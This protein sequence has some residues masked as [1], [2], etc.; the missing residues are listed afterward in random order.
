MSVVMD[1]SPTDRDL[2]WTLS[3]QDV[4]A[5][6]ARR[7]VPDDHRGP[8]SSAESA[9]YADARRREGQLAREQGLGSPDT[10]FQSRVDARVRQRHDD[11][12]LSRSG[13]PRRPRAGSPAGSERSRGSRASARSRTSRGSRGSR[14]SHGDFG[15]GGGGPSRAASRGGSRRLDAGSPS[16]R[17][18]EPP[19]SGD[20]RRSGDREDDEPGCPLRGEA[21][22]LEKQA[23]LLDLERMRINGVVLSRGYDMSD[24]LEDMRFEIQKHEA[25]LDEK[26]MV[27]WMKS[28]LRL[29]LTG[30]ELG[31]QKFGPFLALDGWSVEIT[32]DMNK[33]DLPMSRLYRK[34]W[35]RSTMSP[36]MELAWVILGS[37]GMFHLRQKGGALLS[38]MNPGGPAAPAGAAYSGFASEPF[39]E[40]SAPPPAPAGPPPNAHAAPAGPAQRRMP[41]PDF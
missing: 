29:G 12:E 8:I 15:G 2:F 7:L 24:R 36:E 28:C 1:V 14:G 23:A 18:G 19:R 17:R 37:M 6:D 3:N 22:R 21:I 31:N 27:G 13:S 20:R 25:A 11:G 32:A 10:S 30:I 9:V 39:A 41:V 5:R 26:Q 38:A 40:E 33:F 4:V 35:R 34:Y 16:E